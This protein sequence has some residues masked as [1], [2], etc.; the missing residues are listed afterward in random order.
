V[1]LTQRSVFELERAKKPRKAETFNRSR[2][3]TF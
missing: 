1:N 3:K 2:L